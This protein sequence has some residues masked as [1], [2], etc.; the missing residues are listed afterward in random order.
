[1]RKSTKVPSKRKAGVP[2]GR[3]DG[4]GD[5]PQP[6]GFAEDLE[7]RVHRGGGDRR[8]QSHELLAIFFRE[9]QGKLRLQSRWR[10]RASTLNKQVTADGL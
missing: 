2:T 1:M 4:G 5:E 8:R 9:L 6:G 3:F 7:I 10:Q